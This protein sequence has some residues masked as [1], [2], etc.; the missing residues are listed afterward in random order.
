VGTNLRFAHTDLR[1]SKMICFLLVH[2]NS[3]PK[4][5]LGTGDGSMMSRLESYNTRIAG[6]KLL[7]NLSIPGALIN[8]MAPSVCEVPSSLRSSLLDKMSGRKE[9]DGIGPR[10]TDVQS[11]S[12]DVTSLVISGQNVFQ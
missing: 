9:S 6:G 11:S 7:F 4:N 10:A 1:L 12:T 3:K 5:G 8:K 2:L